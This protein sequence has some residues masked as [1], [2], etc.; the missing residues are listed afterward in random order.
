MTDKSFN[1]KILMLGTRGIPAA[2][3]GFETFVEQ[4]APHLAK[5]GWDVSV[6][7]QDEGNKPIW[8]NKYQGVTLIHVPVNGRGVKSTVFFDWKAMRHAL[9]SEGLLL[10]FGYPTGAFAVIPR[11]YKRRH[12]INMDGIEYRRSQFGNIGKLAYYINER[13]A[14]FFANQL[15]ADHPCIAN[16]LATRTPRRKIATIAYGA[17]EIDNSDPSCLSSFGVV[18]DRYS[19]VIA[20]PEPDNSILELVR[21]FSRR[22]RER[23]LVVLGNFSDRNKYHSAVKAAGS[24]EVVF[25]G[26]IYEKRVLHA[27]RKNAR[28]YA[29][30]HR[31]GGTN[32]SLVEALGA[33]NAILANDNKFN[34]WVADKAAVYFRTEDEI[35]HLMNVLFTD[36]A[37]VEGLRVQAIQRF[38]CNFTWPKILG[39]YEELLYAEARLDRQSY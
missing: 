23:K 10:S 34:R 1:P 38:L 14:A 30:G 6:Y 5:R 22:V 13:L 32:P 3:G 36:D 19:V 16:H 11:L 9:R 37:L 39:E 24:H 20:R 2:H 26:A 7:C 33:G 12:V 8:T 27:L 17:E 29:H 28:F 31:V 21:A 35:D 4:L 15:I 18:P 25:P